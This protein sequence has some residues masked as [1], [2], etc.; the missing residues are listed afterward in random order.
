MQQQQPIDKR[1]FI[2][3][4]LITIIVTGWVI[5]MSTHQRTVNPTVTETKQKINANQ[6]AAVNTTNAPTNQPTISESKED[7]VRIETDLVR[8]MLSTKGGSI[9]RWELKEYSSWHDKT[10]KGVP[11]QLI[12]AKNREAAI[13]F[14]GPEGKKVDT[15]G[16]NFSFEGDQRSFTLKGN[17]S[18]TITAKIILAPGSEIIKTFTLYGNTYACKAGITLKNMENFLPQRYYDMSWKGGLK[19]QEQNSVDESNTSVALASVSGQIEE[20]DATDFAVPTTGQ[21]IGAIDYLATRTKYFVSAIIPEKINPDAM[22][23]VEGIRIGALGDGYTEK[24][25]L[26]YRVR[27]TGGQQ[28]DGFTFYIGP[29]IYDTLQHYGIEKTIN[30]GTFY[31]VKWLVAPIGE[32][33]LLPMLRFLHI[34]I[35]NYGIAILVFSLIM[36]LL[37]YPFSVSQMKSMQKTK[38]VQPLIQKIQEKFKDDRVAL[39]QETMKVYQEYG[40][41]PAGGCLPMILQMPI[42]IALWAVLGSWMDIRQANFFGWITDLSVPD[43]LFDLGFKLPLFQ[44]D[45]LSGLALLMG[46]AMFIQQKMTIT[47]PN[48]K[49]MVY[50]MPIMF[51]FMFSGFPAGLNVYYF[52]FTLLG[53]LQQVWVTKL[54]KNKITLDDLKKMPKSEGWF[55]KRMRMAQEIAQQQK[56]GG[57]ASKSSKRQPIGNKLP[58]SN[59]KK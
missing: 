4:I 59:R 55:A 38:A 9:A 39:S 57:T 10:Y 16:M 1:S 28:T 52:T 27:Y 48:Q 17:D 36:K 19:F 21:T 8:I 23:F 37:L 44:I 54:S 3:F 14:I 56:A 33:I 58:N 47:D 42:L 45:K 13:T 43:V 24:Y 20:Y 11:V 32:Y 34:F 31:G 51:T 5:W 41:N 26:A 6:A 18:L 30:F 22:G 40:I 2:G 25:S 46:L 12:N 53:I 49:S 50:I 15:R 35:S 29:Q 7:F